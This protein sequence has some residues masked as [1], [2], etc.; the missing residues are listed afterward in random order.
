VRV[1]D[2]EG[3]TRCDFCA[4]RYEP[5]QPSAEWLEIMVERDGRYAAPDFCSQEH[6]ARW[7]SE[8][9]PALTPITIMDRTMRDRL[10]DITLALPFIAVAALAAI[11]LWTVIRWIWP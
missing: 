11:G 5:G 8:P 7:F 2:E 10:A 9:L 3:Y 1:V 4:R 6:A